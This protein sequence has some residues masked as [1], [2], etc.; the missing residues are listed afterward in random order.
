MVKRGGFYVENISPFTKKSGY[1]SSTI[2][3]TYQVVTHFRG[4]DKIV[5]KA[6][7]SGI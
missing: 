4:I 2:V 3:S 5:R 6:N 7:S 1:N